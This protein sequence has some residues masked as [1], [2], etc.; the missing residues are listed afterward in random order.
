MFLDADDLE[1]QK[2]MT[3]TDRDIDIVLICPEYSP[4]IY[5]SYFRFVSHKMQKCLLL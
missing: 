4:A 2:A 3:S 1:A 5:V